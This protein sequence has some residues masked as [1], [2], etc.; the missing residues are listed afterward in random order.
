M[1][2]PGG[3]QHGGELNRTPHAWNV[4][5]ERGRTRPARWLSWPLFSRPRFR[6]LACLVQYRGSLI[7]S[8]VEFCKGLGVTQ[9]RVVPQRGF[10]L[11]REGTASSERPLPASAVE[12][13]KIGP[14]HV[15]SLY[16]RRSFPLVAGTTLGV[17]SSRKP[18][19]VP[20]CN[21]RMKNAFCRD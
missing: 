9:A 4:G 15:G 13:F 10:D 3:S 20:L 7:K 11:R 5:K 17:Q 16:S 2:P 8:G 1:Q 18:D 12:R 19:C 21:D 14:I 6:S